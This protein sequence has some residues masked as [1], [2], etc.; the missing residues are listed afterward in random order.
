MKSGFVSALVVAGLLAACASPA[1]R[2]VDRA[3]S[4]PA[5]FPD[6]Y[7]RQAAARGE[8]V[9]AVD[10][11]ASLVVIEVRRGGTLA[12]LGHDH[13]VASHDVQGYVAPADRRADLY[14]RLDGLVV[15]ERELR[16]EASFDTQ[17]SDEAIAG[18]RENM[19]RKLGAEAHPYAR[20]E[21][22]GAEFDATGSRLMV[23]LA[24]NGIAQTMEIPT[25]IAVSAEDVSVTGHMTLA[26][27]SFGI[28]PFSILGGALQVQD[29]VAIR[30]R[31]RARRLPS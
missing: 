25:Q 19:L 27:T 31:I 26:Q 20:I 13:V 10:P 22:R 29:Q 12:H 4:T 9:F 5:D 7:Y 23:T 16:A 1:P 17:P 3:A 15:D 30:F 18:T 21:V 28:T 14:L 11:A 2:P 24:L 6:V 8:P